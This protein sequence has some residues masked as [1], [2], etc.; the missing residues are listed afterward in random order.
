M[1]E[2]LLQALTVGPVQVRVE[3]V[4]DGTDV[5][6]L[7]P[8]YLSAMAPLVSRAAARHVLSRVEFDEEMADKRILKLVVRD[9]EDVPVGLT[10]LTH[11]LEAV[12]WV[13]PSYFSTRFPDAV[14]RDAMYYLGY[15]VVDPARRRSKALVLMAIE[16]NRRLADARGVIAYDICAF[17]DSHGVGRLTRKIFERAHEISRVDTQSYYAA[18]YRAGPGRA[19]PERARRR[20]ERSLRATTLDDRPDLLP[21]LRR[22]LDELWPAALRS[23]VSDGLLAGALSGGHRHQVLLLDENDTVRAAGLTVLVRNPHAAPGTREGWAAAL[24]GVSAGPR[25]DPEAVV[26]PLVPPTRLGSH[27]TTRAV[28]DEVSALARAEGASRLLAVVRPH[29]KRS[30]P[31]IPLADYLT[32]R[33]EGEEALDPEIRA[34]LALGGEVVGT[35]EPETVADRPEW[36]RGLGLPLPTDGS[37]VAEGAP[38]PLVLSAGTGRYRDPQVWVEH[39]T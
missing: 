12:P 37:Y 5:K 3:T 32:W 24:P 33:T 23:P 29:R 26:L 39:R 9:H 13:N 22:L 30:Y 36:E 20:L 17:N 19:H 1:T 21:G 4:V 31:L 25:S 34:H 11:D 14:N 35:T 2:V 6:I 38:A 8:L 28:L 15:T 16:V 10:T 27:D 18:D 7:Y